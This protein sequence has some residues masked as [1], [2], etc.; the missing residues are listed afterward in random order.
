M[1]FRL[2]VFWSICWLKDCIGLC[3]LINKCMN[4]VFF[5]AIGLWSPIKPNRLMGPCIYRLD[6]A[7]T[8]IVWWIT[9]DVW[10]LNNGLKDKTRISSKERWEWVASIVMYRKRKG[11]FKLL[12]VLR[13]GWALVSIHQCW[14]MVDEH[15]PLQ[16]LVGGVDD[17]QGWQKASINSIYAGQ[18]QKLVCASKNW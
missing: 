14:W 16:E 6:R 18:W 17:C 7:V 9:S 3:A 12:V 11:G 2:L 8:D 15:P 5:G 1:H 10:F 13:D 4:S